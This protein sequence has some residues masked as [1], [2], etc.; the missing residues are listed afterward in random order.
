MAIAIF[1][2]KKCKN[3]KAIRLKK[4]FNNLRQIMWCQYSK[5]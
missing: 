3:K 5:K 4:D 2:T 1:K